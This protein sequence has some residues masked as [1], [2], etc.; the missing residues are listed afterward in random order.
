MMLCQAP[1]WQEKDDGDRTALMPD[2]GTDGACWR[3]A[4]KAMWKD[5]SLRY[6]QGSSAGRSSERYSSTPGVD[7][8]DRVIEATWDV[9]KAT[10]F[11]EYLGVAFDLRQLCALQLATGQYDWDD[12][13]ADVLLG[14]EVNE[15]SDNGIVRPRITASVFGVAS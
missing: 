4:S 7:S 11:E 12:G 9:T 14:A 10:G 1:H 8:H 13:F 2:C 6:V 5:Q 15:E 3:N